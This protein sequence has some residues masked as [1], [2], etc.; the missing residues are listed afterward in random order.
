MAF[1]KQRSHKVAMAAERPT[2]FPPEA[3]PDPALPDDPIYQRVWGLRPKTLNA[4]PKS[5]KGKG[6]G[7]GK[8]AS[9]ASEDVVGDAELALPVPH[10]AWQMGSTWR[11]V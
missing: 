10:A 7:K 3:F 9:S 4:H 8:D 1:E 11:L 2:P 5:G 6:K